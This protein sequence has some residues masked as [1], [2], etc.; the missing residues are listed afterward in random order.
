MSRRWVCYF[1]GLLSLETS[2]KS[3]QE[4]KGMKPRNSNELYGDASYS[5]EP[6]IFISFWVCHFEPIKRFHH[7]KWQ[8]N[9][10]LFLCQIAVIS[11]WLWHF[12]C[13]LWTKLIANDINFMHPSVI[14]KWLEFA[15]L[16]MKCRWQVLDCRMRLRINGQSLVRTSTCYALGAKTQYLLTCLISGESVCHFAWGI[17]L[18]FCLVYNIPLTRISKA[19]IHKWFFIMSMK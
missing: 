5:R 2:N 11:K 4:Y 10:M 8:Q 1:M 15:R 7:W 9:D 6:V 16:E 12:K 13:N 19:F 17:W 14:S 3:F 18:T